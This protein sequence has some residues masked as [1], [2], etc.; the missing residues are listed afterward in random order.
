VWDGPSPR[1][2]VTFP[3]LYSFVKG[4]GG[5]HVTVR[6][7]CTTTG[8]HHYEVSAQDHQLVRDADLLFALG[9]TLDEKFAD[10]LAKDGRANRFHYIKLGESLDKK[11]L[12]PMEHHEEHA[13]GKDG[14]GEKEEHE[15]E[16]GAYD[17]HVWLG[18]PQAIAMTE[19]IRDELK[20]A[21]PAHAADYDR[22]AAAYVQTLKETLA[23]GRDMLGAKKNRKLITFHE[24]LQYFARNFDLT[25]VDTME[26]GPG[27]EPRGG[28][29]IQ[30]IDNCV[31]EGVGVIAVEP[32][33]PKT[34]SAQVLQDELRKKKHEVKLVE[35][36][37]LETAEPKELNDSW[38]VRKMRENIDNLAQGLP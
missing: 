13:K 23:Y 11:L 8:P 9:L 21:D 10:A 27:D 17:P 14:K 25:I 31:K 4:V 19:L 33:Y 37:P 22:N 1:V 34:T 18:I 3:P 35:V 29:M 38:Y 5:D 24:S 2:V 36:D 32:Q 15:H 12:L 28:R 26:E 20:K 7:L 30:L 6:C 16:H